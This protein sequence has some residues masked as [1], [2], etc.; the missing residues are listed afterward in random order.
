MTVCH[1]K[2]K[3]LKQHTKNADIVIVAVGVTPDT[4]LAKKI[5]LK[6]G[7]KNSIIVDEHMNTSVNDIYAVG[8]AVEVNNLIT[9]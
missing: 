1:S 9:N 6:L 3:D 4:I 8:D 5:G 2:T 7:L